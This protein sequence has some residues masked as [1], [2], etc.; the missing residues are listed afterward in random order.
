MIR[1]RFTFKGNWTASWCGRRATVYRDR[2]GRWRT[3]ISTDYELDS[4]FFDHTWKDAEIAKQWA[5]E[6]LRLRGGQAE[7]EEGKPTPPPPEREQTA[8][9]VYVAWKAGMQRPANTLPA[10]AVTLGVE[11]PLTLERVKTAYRAAA[12]RAHPDRGGTEEAM[13]RINAAWKEAQQYLVVV[14]GVTL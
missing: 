11:A 8:A 5:E 3:V 1:W 9:P 4:E 13:A 6:A 12:K 14:L 7:G 2:K 10:W